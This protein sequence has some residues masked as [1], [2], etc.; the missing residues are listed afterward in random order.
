MS[1]KIRAKFSF[2]YDEISK[3]I[4][5][6]LVEYFNKL[7]VECDKFNHICDCRQNEEGVSNGK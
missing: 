3:D 5:I 2:E 1:G 7:P 6:L 4:Y